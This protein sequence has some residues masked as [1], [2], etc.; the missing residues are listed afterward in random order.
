MRENE[1]LYRRPHILRF[2]DYPD[3]PGQRPVNSRLTIT[4]ESNPSDAQPAAL[5]RLKN[6]RYTYEFSIYR[7]WKH[8]LT[9]I[10]FEREMIAELYR[11]YWRNVTITL[12][13]MYHLPTGSQTS[14]DNAVPEPAESLPRFEELVLHDGSGSW[15]L[16]VKVD[17]LDGT[18]PDDMQTATDMLMQAKQAFSGVFEFG[19]VDRSTCDTRVKMG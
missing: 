1:E 10:R 3:P 8:L 18:K 16:S 9:P 13:R 19:L 2:A 17:V 7:V 4:I 12:A 5:S 15:V 6:I 11:C 14:V